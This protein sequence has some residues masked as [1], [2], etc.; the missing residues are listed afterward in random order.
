[1]RTTHHARHRIRQS[2]DPFSQNGPFS[3]FFTQWVCTLAATP[4]RGAAA[5]P[6]T[7]GI[8]PSK[9]P[10]RRRHAARGLRMAQ[11]PHRSQPEVHLDTYKTWV[12][13]RLARNNSPNTAPPAAL[14]RKN[15]PASTKTPNVGCFKQAGRTFSRPNET[16]TAFA[17]S[18]TG[19]HETSD[20]FA[21]PQCRT[22]THFWRAKVMAVS[23]THED[24]AAKVTA[25]SS[26][27]SSALDTEP[28]HQIAQ[29]C[30]S[31]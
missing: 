21:R 25:V 12:Q 5:P 20:T 24:R 28:M 22:Y 15:R 2:A 1:M 30:T 8:A 18:F 27:R 31:N 9:P 6:P 23:P 7:G 3:P 26:R 29:H 13:Y 16:A 11:N 14:P 4:P 10:T 17:H 19:T